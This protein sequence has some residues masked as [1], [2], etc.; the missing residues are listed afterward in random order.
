MGRLLSHRVQSIILVSLEYI[1]KTRAKSLLVGTSGAFAVALLAFSLTVGGART[2]RA[3]DPETV[4]YP[5]QE[6]VLVPVKDLQVLEQRVIYLEETVAGLT[7][8]WQHINTHRLCV[9][10]E[11]GATETCISKAQL[12][13]LL[14]GQAKVAAAEAPAAAVE[15]AKSVEEAKISPAEEPVAL[16]ATEDKSEPSTSPDGNQLSE[17]DPGTEPVAVAATE[18]K[19]EPAPSP[20]GN[21]I[22]EKDPGT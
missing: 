12:D 4:S 22:S 18:D 16:A 1:M 19:S 8:S 17:K 21:Q 20:D 15:E 5:G 3:D 14:A 6:T 2:V 10:D 9:S 11:A 13:A 7:E